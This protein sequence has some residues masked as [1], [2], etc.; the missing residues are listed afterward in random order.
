MLYLQVDQG[1]YNLS[2]SSELGVSDKANILS[3][4]CGITD[5]KFPFTWKGCDASF[6]QENVIDFVSYDQLKSLRLYLQ[7][8]R[9]PSGVSIEIRPFYYISNDTDYII[10]DGYN[11]YQGDK[12]I[13]FLGV[14]DIETLRIR[15]ARTKRRPNGGFL[16]IDYVML[17][18][19]GIFT[20]K[21]AGIG[22]DFTCS[23]VVKPSHVHFIFR[24]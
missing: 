7:I 10:H 14:T 16:T 22:G 21:H 24:R 17:D 13:P 9:S 8:E 6:S 19:G 11:S 2:P 1:D 18:S 20:P 5:H 3:C 12:P 23:S 15:L 4:C